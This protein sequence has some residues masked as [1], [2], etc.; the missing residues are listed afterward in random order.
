[1]AAIEGRDLGCVVA[2]GRGDHGRVDG[3]ERELV[4]AG[5]QLRHAEQVGGVDWLEREAAGGQVAEE[6][7]LGL[8]AETAR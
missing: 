6:A 4:V 2:L 8:P 7:N 5:N 3:S 1:M